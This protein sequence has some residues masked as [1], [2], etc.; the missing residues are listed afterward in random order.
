MLAE[1]RFTRPLSVLICAAALLS[2][3]LAHAADLTPIKM[4]FIGQLNRPLSNVGE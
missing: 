2:A 3:P 1:I 4:A